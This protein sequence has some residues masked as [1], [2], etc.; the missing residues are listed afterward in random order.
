[1]NLCK[2]AMTAFPMYQTEHRAFALEALKRDGHYHFFMAPKPAP[3]AG[4]AKRVAKPARAGIMLVQAGQVYGAKAR[5][6]RRFVRVQQVRRP[7]DSPY[8]LCVEVSADGNK[9]SGWFHD[10]DRGA[11]FKVAL[12]MDPAGN[13]AMPPW[14]ALE[15]PKEEV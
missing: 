1:C 13:W 14:Y 8:A 7:G 15:A 10:V 6:G 2:V 9:L 5:H 4:R 11:P 12:T 3:A